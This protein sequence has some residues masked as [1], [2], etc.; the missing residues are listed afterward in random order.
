MPQDAKNFWKSLDH[1]G[2]AQKANDKRVLTNK[3]LVTEIETIKRA[4]KQRAAGFGR[5]LSSP[6]TAQFV[7]D[8]S[9]REAIFDATRLLF[10]YLD[11]ANGISNNDKDKIDAFLRNFLPLLFALQPTEFALEMLPVGGEG[12]DLESIEGVSDAGTSALGDVSEVTS[13]VGS[14][15]K[16]GGKKAA[17][18]LRKKALKNAGGPGSRAGGAGGGRR[19]KVSSPAP[20][21]RDASP[22]PSTGADTPAA[23]TV[24]TDAMPTI[25]SLASLIT[26]EVEAEIAANREQ[27]SI[28][29]SSR[30]ASAM[31]GGDDA[32]RSPSVGLGGESMERGDSAMSM[33]SAT[34]SIAVPV[35]PVLPDGPLPELIIPVDDKP[36][37]V[38]TRRQWNFFANSNLYCLVRLFQVSC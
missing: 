36:A 28:V 10:S 29:D 23:D 21:S 17:A 19:S 37:R 24:M 12:D 25:T 16:R 5:P 2:I 13:V 35:V 14:T 32:T 4:Q 18:D 6:L 33:I 8:V 1:Q 15:T 26:P 7:Y 11:R 31:L 3:A 30:E 9:D 38:E 20:S 34:E 22:A 27:S